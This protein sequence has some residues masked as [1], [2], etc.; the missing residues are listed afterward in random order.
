VQI[1]QDDVAAPVGKG[2][3]NSGAQKA[4]STITEASP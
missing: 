2:I 1:E 4:F 3:G